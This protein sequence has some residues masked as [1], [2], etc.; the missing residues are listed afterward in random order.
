M[1]TCKASTREPWQSSPPEQE[2]SLQIKIFIPNCFATG[3]QLR[4]SKYRKA[5]NSVQ[6][7]DAQKHKVNMEQWLS[8]LLLPHCWLIAKVIMGHTSCF[9]RVSASHKNKDKAILA[10]GFGGT[11]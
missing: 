8:A 9:N 3:R 7:T 1:N 6:L 2:L 11:C 5:L 4:H 10:T